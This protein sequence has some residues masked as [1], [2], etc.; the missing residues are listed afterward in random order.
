MTRKSTSSPSWPWESIPFVTVAILL[1]SSCS[2]RHIIYPAPAI[3]VGKPPSGMEEVWLD[4]RRGVSILAWHRDGSRLSPHRPTLLYFHG[5]GENLETMRL[6]GSLAELDKLGVPYL[7][8]D[9]PGY[10]RSS[11]APSE[12]SIK[13]A[14]EAA[15]Q[16]LVRRYP[17]RPRIVCGWSLGAAVATYLAATS[18]DLQGLVALSAWTSLADVAALHFPSW[19]TGI[20]LRE[21]YDSA[22]VAVGIEMPSLVIHGDRDE[23]IPAAQGR[24]LAEAIPQ[25]E[26]LAIEAA[27]HNDLLSNGR[28]WRAISGFLNLV[29]ANAAV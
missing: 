26:W 9:Y 1:L 24:A 10:G 7:A 20:L 28:V 11:G 14:G 5:N 12:A 29:E 2:V 19:L 6:S 17:D 13:E 22:E 15:L 16:W 25:A 27:G 3:S 23:I 21:S 8:V 4:T 18:K